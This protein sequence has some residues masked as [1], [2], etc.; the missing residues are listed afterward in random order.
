M[1]MRKL[2]MWR[3]LRLLSLHIWSWTNPLPLT[4]GPAQPRPTSPNTPP[5]FIVTATILQLG[6]AGG[7]FVQNWEGGDIIGKE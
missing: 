1:Q 5:K 2:S 7:G 4:I 3:V 6:G